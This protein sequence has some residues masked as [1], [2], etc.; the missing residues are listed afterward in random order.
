MKEIEYYIKSNNKLMEEWEKELNKTKVES[1]R[2][3]IKNNIDKVYYYIKG[4]KD[5]K[6]Y[7]EDEEK[8]KN[9]ER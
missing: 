8:A 1:E 4:L 3:R 7:I 6:Q 2:L 5:A 9:E